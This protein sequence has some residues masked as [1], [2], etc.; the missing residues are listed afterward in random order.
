MDQEERDMNYPPEAFRDDEFRD[1]FGEGEQ[2]DEIFGT[3]DITQYITAEEAA[4]LEQEAAD[5]SGT[6]D[7][8]PEAV[9]EEPQKEKAPMKKGRPSAGWLGWVP[10]TFL[11]SDGNPLKPPSLWKRATPLR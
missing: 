3:E 8:L 1:A 10:R 7:V 2:L 9:S 6:D 11:P 4:L 5:A